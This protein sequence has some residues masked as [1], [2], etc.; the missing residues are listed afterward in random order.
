M[1]EIVGAGPIASGP[2]HLR[3]VEGMRAVAAL[4][5]YLNHAYA[6][7]FYPAF[8]DASLGLLSI[9]RYSMVAGHL[10]VTVFI[11]ISGFCLT[12]PVVAS[13]DRLRGGTIGFFKRRARR[14][15]PAYYG[16][17]AFALVLIWTIIGNP[18][19]TL[20]DVPIGVTPAA[21]LSHVLLLQDLFGTSKI[22]YVLWSIAVEWHIYFLFPWLVWGW[23]RFGAGKTVTTALLVGYGLHFAFH[24]TRLMRANPHFLGMFALGMLAAYITTSRHDGYLRLRHGFP[25]GL[26]LVFTTTLVC[27]L[28]GIWGVRTATERFY[29]LD[30]PVAVMTA[31][32]LVL[33]SR[34]EGS[35]FSDVFAWKPIAV[36]GTFSY[37]LYLL[38]APLLQI[39]WQYVLRPANVG[40]LAMFVFLMTVGLAVVLVVAYLFYRLFEEPFMRSSAVPRQRDTIPTPV[41]LA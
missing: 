9:A 31:S 3:H 4:V 23:R 11:V 41:V 38:H 17:L 27:A 14:I 20:W 10:A 15:L 1:V 40:D 18:T 19:G 8:N 7:V 33:S 22:N 39:L 24:S 13:D 16:S 30:A 28:V 26:T 6:Q 36:I 37:S 35:A 2:R 29:L 12:L 32:L 5:V 25:W 34:A 21:I